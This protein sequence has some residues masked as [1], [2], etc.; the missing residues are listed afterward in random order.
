MRGVVIYLRIM[1]AVFALSLLAVGLNAVFL[2]RSGELEGLSAVVA[3]QSRQDGLYNSQTFSYLDY[4]DAMYLRRLPEVITLGSSRALQ[5]RDYAFTV[6][7]YNLGGTVRAQDQ[8]FRVTDRMFR[9]H[10]PQVVF[11]FLDFWH[12]CVRGKDI[13]TLRPPVVASVK[14]SDKPQLTA[15]WIYIRNGYISIDDYFKIILGYVNRY[16]PM[17]KIG[18]LSMLHDSGASVDGSQYYGLGDPVELRA[19][20]FKLSLVDIGHDI[21][22]EGCSFSEQTMRQVERLSTELA[23]KGVRL[24]PVIAPMP[25]SV[26]DRMRD[27]GNFAY[28]EQWRHEVIRRLPDAYDFHDIRSL[29]A[30][31]CEFHDY[32]HGGE[33]A[34]LRILRAIADSDPSL[35]RIVDRQRIDHLIERH[36]GGLTV[37]D[38][39]VGIAYGS[40]L[41]RPVD[42]CFT[43][44]GIR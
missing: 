12:F 30:T 40:A 34:Y 43:V 24:V 31:D 38:N 44:G 41:N 7:F 33:V 28:I 8:A 4:K 37:A 9:R 32:Y 35:A 22:K 6:P 23:G 20:R 25:P 19:S 11:Y 13:P 26:L 10:R 5:V 18:F 1:L 21:F 3:A 16:S 27:V 36:R 17:L 15:P 2:W 42:G 29:G 14:Y 39:A